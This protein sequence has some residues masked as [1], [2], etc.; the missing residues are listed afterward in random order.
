M[1]ELLN[2]YNNPIEFSDMRVSI[3]ALVIAIVIFLILVALCLIA[4]FEDAVVQGIR[5]VITST[6]VLGVFVWFFSYTASTEDIRKERLKEIISHE[7]SS[8]LVITDRYIVY[9]DIVIRH[10]IYNISNYIVRLNDGTYM[11]VEE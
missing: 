3:G 10:N 2:N 9:D 4:I 7:D 1:E 11:F 8:D 6:I 5:I